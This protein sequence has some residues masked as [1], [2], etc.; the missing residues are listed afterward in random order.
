MQRV[1]L[2]LLVALALDGGVAASQKPSGRAFTPDDLFRVRRVG[3]VTWSPDGRTVAVEFS[4]PS[5]WLIAVPTNEIAAFDVTTRAMRIISDRSSGYV[6]FFGAVWAPDSRR[7]AFL[8]VDAD[9]IVRVWIWSVGSNAPTVVPG[10]DV[11]ADSGDPSLAWVDS[12]RLAVLAWDD[13]AEKSGGFYLPLLRGRNAADGWKR[14]MDGRT[15][16]VSVMSSGGKPLPESPHARL[17]V[18]D[19]ESGARKTLA[20]GRLNR[21]AVAAD[22]CCVSFFRNVPAP[23]ASYF[24]LARGAGDVDAAYVAVTRGMTREAVDVRT[25]AKV[26]VLVTAPRAAAR[27]TVPASPPVPNGRWI[28]IAPAGDAALYAAN[29]EDGSRVWIAGGGGRPLSSTAEIWRDNE[30]MRDVRTGRAQSLSYVTPDGKTLTAWLLLPPG[31]VSG[32]RVPMITRVYPGTV[33]DSTTP[34]ALSPHFPGDFEHA[35][36]FAALGY[37]VLLPSIPTKPDDPSALEPLMAGVM[38]AIDAAVASGIADPD[39]LALVGQSGG[40]FATLGLITQTNRFRSAIAS[41][42]YSNFVSLYGTFYGTYRYGDA[43][44]PETAQVLSMLQLE[45]GFMGLGADPW[46]APARYSSNSPLL[47]ADKVGTPVMLIKGDLD[48]I[49]VQQAEEFFT[50]L[51]RRDKRAVFLRY[52]GEEHGINERQNVIDVWRRMTEWL[53][54]TMGP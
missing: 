9:A 42:A 17:L 26:D 45:H 34:V 14:A 29:G 4:K 51:L 8:S 16:T 46:T 43:G 31:H 19:V 24:E 41:A 53:A 30:W 1:A 11:R 3:A 47:R 7:L 33:Y 2:A 20:R 5:R 39:R 13:G 54:E 21:L 38:P 49:P 15:P 44:R 12:T 52:A 35:Q 18:V 32:T 27:P 48:Y 10:I 37:A 6:G 23:V 50:A 22:G 25:A 40:G 36:L 28:G